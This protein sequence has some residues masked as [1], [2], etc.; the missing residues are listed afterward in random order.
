MV[1]ARSAPAL[2]DARLQAMLHAMCCILQEGMQERSPRFCAHSLS[3]H[4]AALFMHAK[5]TL[6]RSSSWKR[7]GGGLSGLL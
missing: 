7:G 5:L 4:C 3:L 2:P 1:A 6:I